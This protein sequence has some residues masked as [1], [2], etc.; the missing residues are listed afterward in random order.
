TATELLAELRAI[1]EPPEL[2]WDSAKAKAGAARTASLLPKNPKGMSDAIR[3]LAPALRMGGVDVIFRKATNK[4]PLITIRRAENRGNA[5]SRPSPPSPDAATRV[6]A[7]DLRCDGPGD[8]RSSRRVD[9]HHIVTVP[10]L[11]QCLPTK[12][13]EQDE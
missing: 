10:S 13:L 1:I 5:P 4:S 9:R 12:G 7:S 3:R 2:A 11:A 8:G 6:A